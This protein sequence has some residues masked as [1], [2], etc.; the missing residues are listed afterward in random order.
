[1]DKDT[2]YTYP[3]FGRHLKPFLPTAFADVNSHQD[4]LAPRGG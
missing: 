1:M 4:A 2:H 3:C